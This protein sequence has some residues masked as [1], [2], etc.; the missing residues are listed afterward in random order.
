[1]S[2]S[3]ARTG[4]RESTGAGGSETGG[5][6]SAKPCAGAREVLGLERFSCIEYVRC[7]EDASSTP[8]SNRESRYARNPRIARV[9][10]DLAIT[11]ELGEG[12]RRIFDE[13]RVN[14][15]SDP[16]Y[17]QTAGSVRL[18]LASIARLDPHVEKRLPR[19][20]RD[21]L[22]ALRAAGQPLGTGEVSELVG[23]SGRQR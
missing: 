18:T 11:Q 13:M 4:P 15:L 14:G 22:K 1:M 23:R 16:I 9:C 2:S 19:G 8:S 6:W 20:A 12:I 7:S 3:R 10:S 17:Q 21:V 5:G